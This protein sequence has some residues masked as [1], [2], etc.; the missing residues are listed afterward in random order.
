[1]PRLNIGIS[2]EDKAFLEKH[3]EF[4]ASGVFRNA[5]QKIREEFARKAD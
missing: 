3:K 5:M 2:E 1:M 4:R